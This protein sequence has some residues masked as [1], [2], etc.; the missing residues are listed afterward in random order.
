MIRCSLIQDFFQYFT[1]SSHRCT[2]TAI[3]LTNEE[4][5]VYSGHQPRFLNALPTHCQHFHRTPRMGILIYNEVSPG[6]EPRFLHSQRNAYSGL[7][8]KPDF[9]LGSV[10]VHPICFYRPAVCRTE[11][12]NKPVA[13]LNTLFW[14]FTLV[15]SFSTLIVC[16]RDKSYWELIFSFSPQDQAK[17]T[18]CR[19][20]LSLICCFPGGL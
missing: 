17:V 18:A 13:D 4:T 20:Q 8:L 16:H 11:T 3:H 5:E 9:T 10:Q 15:A 7:G 6:L 14:S 1:N 12:Q 2:S 19:C